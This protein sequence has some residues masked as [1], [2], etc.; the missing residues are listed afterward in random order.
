MDVKYEIGKVQEEITFRN[1][2]KFIVAR[3]GKFLVYHSLSSNQQ[4]RDHKDIAALLG[5]KEEDI[6]GGG[7]VQLQ[8]TDHKS[9]KL[10]IYG[11]SNDYGSV[12]NQILKR[13]DMN[14][15]LLAYLN[16]EPGIES[17]VFDTFGKEKQH[18]GQY[19]LEEE[20]TT[21]SPC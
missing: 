7:H 15:M 9:Y 18:W 6:L 10:R 14:K 21:S 3:E 16:L 1:P 12:P 8:P 5:I 17:I 4:R 19:G 13:F 20:N 2:H 11:N